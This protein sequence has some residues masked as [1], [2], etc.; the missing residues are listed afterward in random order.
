LWPISFG[1]DQP[2][3]VRLVRRILGGFVALLFLAR[4]YKIPTLNSWTYARPRGCGL[5]HRRIGCLLS[6]DWDLREGPHRGMAVGDAF[7][8]GVF[9]QQKPVCNGAGRPTAAF[10][11]TPIYEFSF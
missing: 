3:W 4:H 9:P 8:H 6:G 10:T 5:R 2:V 1:A 7:P 11:P